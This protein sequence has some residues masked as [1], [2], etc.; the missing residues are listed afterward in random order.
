MPFTVRAP[1][2]TASRHSG[3]A[4]ANSVLNA[5]FSFYC[6]GRRCGSLSF[7]RHPELR[8]ATGCLP[9]KSAHDPNF[10]GTSPGCFLSLVARKST[11]TPG[12]CS[13]IDSSC[14]SSRVPTKIF[15]LTFKPVKSISKTMNTHICRYNNWE[16]A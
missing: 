10:G 14:Q 5:G 1:L 13:I 3:Y 4:V 11:F 2:V 9:P 15:S 8:A 12:F 6:P 16:T 7:H